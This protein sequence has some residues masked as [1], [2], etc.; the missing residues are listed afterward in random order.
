MQYLHSPPLK[1]QYLSAQVTPNWHNW[2]STSTVEASSDV[3]DWSLVWDHLASEN[4][5][6]TF[7]VKPHSQNHL[8]WISEARKKVRL[9]IERL[10]N[11]TCHLGHG[12]CCGFKSILSKS[13]QTRAFEHRHF[14]RQ[15]PAVM[16]LENRCHQAPKWWT[17]Q[18]G[19]PQL[20]SRND[21]L[22]GGLMPICC[23]LSYC[24][25]LWIKRKI[26]DN[27]ESKISSKIHRQA[28]VSFTI[29][30]WKSAG[31][32]LYDMWKVKSI[33]VFDI[34]DVS[35]TTVKESIRN[36]TY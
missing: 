28:N 16:Q 30:T 34:L 3:T 4:G 33:C 11:E 25:M 20:L 36:K 27:Y 5:W 9:E 26:L 17:H 7:R 10:R 1:F 29:L 14:V 24:I 23:H 8:E 6:K 32:E 18:P 21:C 19:I 12:K 2:T 31:Y 35:T 13:E 22:E 15:S